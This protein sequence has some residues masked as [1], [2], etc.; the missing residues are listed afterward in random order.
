MSEN[1]NY[2][3]L[4][5]GRFD[6]TNDQHLKILSLCKDI[7]WVKMNPTTNKPVADIV[8]LGAWILK[9]G[10]VKKPL[11]KHSHTEVSKLIYQLEKV[12]NTSRA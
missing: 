3:H 12:K 5:A 2:T 4:N 6:N 1:V 9:Y 10:Y 8:R 7:G 11:L